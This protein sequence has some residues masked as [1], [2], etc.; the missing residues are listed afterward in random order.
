M[1]GEV[2]RGKV[3]KGF[4]CEEKYFE[5][6]PVF[7]WEPVEVVEDRGDMIAAAGGGEKAGAELFKFIY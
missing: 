5:V 7:D 1:D 4:V 6:D 3:V 2:W